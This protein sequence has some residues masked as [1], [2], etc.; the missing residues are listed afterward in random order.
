M[1]PQ[2]AVSRT[3]VEQRD[4]QRRWDYAYQFLL[5]WVMEDRAGNALVPSHEQ[6]EQNGNCTVCSSF[7]QS[8]TADTDD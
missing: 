5:R 4:G 3:F 1:K 8:A 6:E 2:R 7:D